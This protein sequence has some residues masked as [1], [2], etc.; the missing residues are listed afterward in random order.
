VTR[1]ED[2]A[3]RM[4]C[5]IVTRTLTLPNSFHE[6]LRPGGAAPGS[7]EQDLL[8]LFAVALPGRRPVRPHQ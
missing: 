4:V 6:P 5:A 3:G 8:R 1:A 2:A 7:F